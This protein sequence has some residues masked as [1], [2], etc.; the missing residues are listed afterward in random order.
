MTDMQ[1][2]VEA[3]AGRAAIPFDRRGAE[4]KKSAPITIYTS[5]GPK[6]IRIDLTQPPLIEGLWVSLGQFDFA[7]QEATVV[8][9][10]A[11]TT[12][13]V[14]TDAVQFLPTTP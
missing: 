9:S 3:E 7:T 6:V 8:V 10:N 1:Y 14:V 12:G 5:Q 4:H 11:G 13:L 2:V